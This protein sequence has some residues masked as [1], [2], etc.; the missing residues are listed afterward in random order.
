MV[1]KLAWG[2]QCTKENTGGISPLWQPSRS[3]GSVL[4]PAHRG[5]K[6]VCTE[7]QQ[8]CP[9]SPSLFIQLGARRVCISKERSCSWSEVRLRMRWHGARAQETSAPFRGIE[10][11]FY[12]NLLRRI[13]CKWPVCRHP[14][15]SGFFLLLVHGGFHSPYFAG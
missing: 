14:V 15:P 5:T 9:P 1:S 4:M 6:L 11:S 10:M 2:L 8:T 12:S 7:E 13:L 3:S